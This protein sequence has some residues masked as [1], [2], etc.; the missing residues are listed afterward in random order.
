MPATAATAVQ[1]IGVLDLAAGRAV[2]ARGG[3]RAAYAPARSALLPHGSPPGD[4]PALARAYAAALGLRALYLAD[5]DAIAGGPPQ[6]ALVRQVAAA[7]TAA[8]GPGARVLVDAGVAT[9]G[10]ALAALE[11]GASSVVVGLET[12]R[13]FDEL[14]DVAAA[15]GAARTL[16]SLDLRGGAPVVH[17]GAPHAGDAPVALARRAAA[18]G[19]GGLILL[20]LARV[21][22]GVGID[23]ALLAE[24]RR[25]LPDRSLLAGGGVRDASDLARLAAAG[26]TGALVATALHDG[27]ITRDDVA[28][29]QGAR[30]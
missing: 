6:H 9:P 14:R 30:G 22:G 1:V 29:V 11:A 26:C 4:A 20:D 10:A 3:T 17:A 16:F 5:L 27:R 13:S 21:G 18:A 23:L 12:L 15:A 2:H 7:F 25:A 28:A 24:L 19:A 8:A